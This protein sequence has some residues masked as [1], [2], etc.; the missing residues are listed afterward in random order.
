MDY[1]ENESLNNVG[2]LKEERETHFSICDDNPNVCI[3]DTRQV[4]I[5]NKIQKLKEYGV[6]EVLDEEKIFDSKR[7]K[8]RIIS[9]QYKI[10]AELL[11][12]RKPRKEITEEQR[13][14]MAE[15]LRRNRENGFKK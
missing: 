9:G 1:L 14:K 13:A 2:Y 4:V 10:P 15:N 5:I 8:E 3:I 11:T 6:V 12:I 7:N